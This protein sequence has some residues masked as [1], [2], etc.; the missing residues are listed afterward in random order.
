MPSAMSEASP[1]VSVVMPVYNR[2]TQLEEAAYSILK[3]SYADLELICVDDG[4]TDKSIEVLNRLAAS[5]PRVRVHPQTNGG[6]YVA[7]NNGALIARGEL[8]AMIDADDLAMPDRIARQVAFFDA[9][10]DVVLLG[11]GMVMIDA[12]G[13]EFRTVTVPTT[14][15]EIKKT[16]QNFNCFHTTTVMM[17]KSAFDEIGG[18]RKA[19]RVAGD[20]DLWLRM[21]ERWKLANLNEPLAKYRVHGDQI[22]TKKLGPQVISMLVCKAAAKVRTT[23][24]KDPLVDATAITQELVSRLGITQ[25]QIRWHELRAYVWWAELVADA[26]QTDLALEMLDRASELSNT[27]TTSR[28]ELARLHRGYAKAYNLQK[29]TLRRLTSSAMAK[30]SE[31]DW[32]PGRIVQRVARKFV[33]GNR[34]YLP[35]APPPREPMTE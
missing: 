24:G 5:D 15:P 13:N 18:Y 30:L 27:A 17:R 23:T 1:R 26:G 4:S 19:F 2:A 11:G 6:A 31:Q 35:P 8:L 25:E 21:A 9:N 12:E 3:G 16:L 29:R 33:K 20:Y 34:N 10:P 22:S 28:A 32:S 14:D 7:R